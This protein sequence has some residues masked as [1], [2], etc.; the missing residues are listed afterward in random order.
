MVT[1]A[2]SGIGHAVT[3]R[4]LDAGVSVVALGRSAADLPD[5]EGLSRETVDLSKLDELPATLERIASSHPEID[6]L[7]L[8]AGRGRF[9]GLEEFSYAQMRDLMELNFLSHA[10]VCRAFVPALRRR[11]DSGGGHIVFLASEAA[12]E[13]SHSGSIYCASKFALRGFAQAL[14][15]EL[16]R[17]GV[18]VTTINPGMVDTPFFDEL[19]FEPGPEP[20]N[21]LTAGQVAEAVI[22]A[23]SLPPSAVIDEINLSPLKRTVRKK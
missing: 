12:L 22:T 2:T 16:A 8:C 23:L 21:R 18:G 9:G 19:D 3:E 1:G 20:E 15:K 10:Y 14:R 17:S 11:S 7:V 4:L 6:A 5:R 13:G